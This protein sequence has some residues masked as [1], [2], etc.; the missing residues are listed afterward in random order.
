MKSGLF[1]GAGIID[2]GGTLLRKTLKRGVQDF[3]DALP[4]FGVHVFV[5]GGLCVA[6]AL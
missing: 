6:L 2:K 4:T 1:L 5:R 3:L